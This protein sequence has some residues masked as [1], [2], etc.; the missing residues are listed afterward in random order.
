MIT[1]FQVITLMS[2]AGIFLGVTTALG[3]YSD[4]E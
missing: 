4:E 2:V 3:A 1:F